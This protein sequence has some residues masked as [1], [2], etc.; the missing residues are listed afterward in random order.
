[1]DH[2][3]LRWLIIKNVKYAQRGNINKQSAFLDEVLLEVPHPDPLRPAFVK[4]RDQQV[5]VADERAGT[6]PSVVDDQ[7][8]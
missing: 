2:R 8:L 3:T 1:M 5:D 7:F 6:T 4:Q